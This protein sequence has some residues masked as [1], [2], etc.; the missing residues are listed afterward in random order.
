[1]ARPRS[2]ADTTAA[3]PPISPDRTNSGPPKQCYETAPAE[4]ADAINLAEESVNAV[5]EVDPEQTGAW[6]W[7]YG[8]WGMRIRLIY[9][10]ENL[11]DWKGIIH[12]VNQN[13]QERFE[14]GGL[15]MAVRNRDIHVDGEIGD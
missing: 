2:A 11:D 6:F 1:M 3:I 4:M 8:D 7:E 10:I 14:D 12:H 5:D 9:H 15:E 13:I